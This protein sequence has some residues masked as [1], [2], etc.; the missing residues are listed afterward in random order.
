MNKSEKS[1]CFPVFIEPKT[2]EQIKQDAEQTKMLESLPQRWGS[3]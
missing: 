1:N 3:T 2:P